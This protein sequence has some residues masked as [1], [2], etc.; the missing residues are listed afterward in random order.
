M[1]QC[2]QSFEAATTACASSISI[3]LPEGHILTKL[4][5]S[6]ETWLTSN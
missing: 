4:K 3:E 1:Q 2:G 6:R 5:E